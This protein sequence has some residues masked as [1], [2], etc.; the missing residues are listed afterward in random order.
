MWT[1]IVWPPETSSTTSGSSRSG[2]SRN[3]GVE[4]ALEVVDGH[5]R[6]VPHQ[7]EGLGRADA[8]EQRADQARARRWRPRRRPR[9]RPRPASTS[10]SATTGVSSSTWA[11]LAISGTTPPKRAW[12]SIWLATT[13][14]RT[15]VARSTT[16]AAVSSHEVSMPRM[17]SA[18]Q[19]SS[20][21]RPGQTQS[22]S[23]RPWSRG[24]R[25]RCRQAAGVLGAVDVGGPHHQGVLAVLGV[26][27]LAHAGGHEAEAPVQRLGA[28][29]A[30]PHLEREVVAAPGDRRAG[31]DRQQPGGDAVPVPPGID[32]DRGDVA[33]V[34]AAQHAR[35]ADDLVADPG[36]QVEPAW[37]AGRSS[38]RNNPNV[39]GRG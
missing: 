19:S 4:V 1:S 30:D 11:R 28:V 5:E 26:V 37:T 17:R 15:R 23:I 6:H 2:S 24:R 25:P 31:R 38:L 39:H 32:R 27:A 36:D 3:D 10:A 20:L 35:V 22:P 18:M 12:R 7:R 9:R 29:V 8:D 33:V 21:V 14:D 16:A 34:E 13:D